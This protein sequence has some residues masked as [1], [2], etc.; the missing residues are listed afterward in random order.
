MKKKTTNDTD[1]TDL[2]RL[3]FPIRAI[4]V[5]RGERWPALCLKVEYIGQPT[6]VTHKNAHCRLTLRI[7]GLINRFALGACRE[8]KTINRET[9][10]K[11]KPPWR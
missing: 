4:R 3:L 7:R 5:I 10:A 6:V 8:H 11:R 1:G 9:G 2:K